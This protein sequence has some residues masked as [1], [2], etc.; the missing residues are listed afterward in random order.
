MK[1]LLC[2]ATGSIGTQLLD[3]IDKKQKIVGITFNKNINQ[4]KKIIK[5]HN[6]KYF[7]CA[8]DKQYSNVN[9]IEELIKKS[10][11]DLIVNAVVGIAG[12]KITI[13]ALKAKIDLALANKESLVIAGKFVTQLAKKNKVKIIPID[14]EHSSLYQL[15]KNR[16]IKSIDQLIITCSGGSAYFKTND[17]LKKMNF[18]DIIKHPNWNM[19]YK[20][21]IDSATLINK[22]FEIVEAYWL[23]N[24]KKIKAVLH[25]ESIV[26]AMI[27][28]NDGSFFMNASYPDMKLPIKLAIN[29]YQDI[30]TNIKNIDFNNLTLS[31]DE[32]DSKK[33]IPIKWAYQ[34]IE[35][36]NNV[37]GLIINAANEIAIDLFKYNKISFLE[38]IPFINQY[39]IK[40]K[41]ENIKNFDNIFYLLDKINS[42]DYEQV[43][44]N[45]RSN[46]NNN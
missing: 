39:I 25:K 37:L 20:I 38:I 4:A 7:L 13:A 35:D 40:Y 41:K 36:K 11:P 6:V 26:H 23:F 8:N 45:I 44:Q 19:G 1:I 31:F 21:S 9:N 30:E 17:E 15:I 29:N 42:S 34:I 18:N 14:S 27:K 46:K 33:H 3:V 10:K 22:C 2:G 24:T 12:L 43:I 32:I 16:N 5:Q 28:N